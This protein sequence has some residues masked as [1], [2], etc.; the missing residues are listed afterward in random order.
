MFSQDKIEELKK[1]KKELGK[2]STTQVINMF[3]Y[4]IIKLVNKGIQL[5]LL[6]EKLSE[7]L[8]SEISYKYLSRWVKENKTQ[9]GSH[10][11]WVERYVID[12]TN[13]VYVDSP[14]GGE[15]GYSNIP[16]HATIKEVKEA[17]Y[18]PKLCNMCEVPSCTQ[19]CPVA[20]TFTTPDGFVIV[21]SEHCVGCGYCVQACPYGVRFINEKTEENDKNGIIGGTANKCTWCYHRVRKGKLPACVNACPTG[22]RKFGDLNDPTSEVAKIWNA[23]SRLKVLKKDL[24]NEPSLYYVD[25]HAEVV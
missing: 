15:K 10:R 17:F 5:K 7:E 24:G 12:M 4:E 20:A 6:S 16:I 8:G 13:K 9:E 25:L 22:A 19:V 18:V 1:M 23:T 2:L 21:D 11:T 14:H 3:G